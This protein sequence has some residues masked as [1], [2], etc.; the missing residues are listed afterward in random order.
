LW[1]AL[2]LVLLSQGGIAQTP[3]SGSIEGSV[4]AR[5]TGQRIDRANLELRR[6]EPAASP[7]NG[8]RVF[9][10][11]L[12]PSGGTAPLP[13]NS[14]TT[15][16]AA[17]GRFVFEDVPPGP[18]RLYAT[19]SNGYVPGAEGRVSG[20]PPH[21]HGYLEVRPSTRAGDPPRMPR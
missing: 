21:A 10:S 17:D 18:Y 16:T 9:V 13:A 2:A 14:K 3:R 7:E 6:A 19:R 12:P 15:T 20:R 5:D 11:G 4:V 8:G 1:S